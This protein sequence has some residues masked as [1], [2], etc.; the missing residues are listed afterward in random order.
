M[1]ALSKSALKSWSVVWAEGTFK[2]CASPSVF[3]KSMSAL[4]GHDVF[5]GPVLNGPTQRV[6][7][8]VSEMPPKKICVGVLAHFTEGVLVWG[9]G[10]VGV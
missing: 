3:N 4:F 6:Q 5:G 8:A 2:K 10:G 9:C 7:D 1:S